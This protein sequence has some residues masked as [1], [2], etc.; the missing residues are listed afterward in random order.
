MLDQ[1][2]HGRRSGLV[3]RSEGFPPDGWES[4]SAAHLEPVLDSVAEKPVAAL[5]DQNGGVG[6]GSL[7]Y[8][9]AFVPAEDAVC[10]GT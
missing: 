6:V 4:A 8:L 7:G 1:V 9:D 10:V 5:D 2:R 3:P